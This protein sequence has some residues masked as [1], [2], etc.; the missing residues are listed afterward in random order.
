MLLVLIVGD[1]WSL[2][3]NFFTFS[4]RASEVFRD[5]AI[6]SFLRKVP[7]P[8]RVIDAASPSGPTSIL[9][10]YGIPNALGYHGFELRAYDEL[11][12]K[13]EGWSNLVTPTLIDL[14]SIRYLLLPNAG[15]VPGFHEAVGPTVMALGSQAVLYE[16]DTPSVYARVA[17]TAVKAPEGS[18]LSTL[19]DPRFPSSDVAH[20]RRHVVGGAESGRAAAAEVAGACDGIEVGAG[21]DDGVA[22]W[23]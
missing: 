13:S 23:L 14:L 2:D 10:G 5:D 9:M 15:Q 6:T 18:E 16:R 17:L 8:Y 11:G 19:V 3:R 1:L 12:G 22:R 21:G 20:L 7:K 4:G